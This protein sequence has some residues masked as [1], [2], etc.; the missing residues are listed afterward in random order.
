[1][2]AEDGGPDTVL[3]VQLDCSGSQVPGAC[4]D[5]W[6]SGS[7]PEA[8]TGIDHGVLLDAALPFDVVAGQEYLIRL[9]RYENISA[10]DYV[11]ELQLEV[12]SGRVPSVQSSFGSPLRLSKNLQEILLEWSPSCMTLDSD[13]AV[14]RGPIGLFDLHEPLSCSSGDPF[15]WSEPLAGDSYYYLIVPNNLFNEGSYG[16]GDTGGTA[17]ERPPSPSACYPQSIGVCP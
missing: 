13:Y 17:W 11:L 8:C 7:E 1:M 6:P 5:D 2:P 3:S 9:A 12:P 10:L 14:Y 4:N 16:S 15:R